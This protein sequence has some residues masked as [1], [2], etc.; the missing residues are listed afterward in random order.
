MAA[1]PKLLAKPPAGGAATSPSPSPW[2]RDEK[3]RQEKKKEADLTVLRDVEIAELEEKGYLAP[4][5]QERL[6]RLRLDQE[7]ERRV[8]EASK[9]DD[10]AGD[11]D[12]DDITDRAAVGLTIHLHIQYAQFSVLVCNSLIKILSSNIQSI[13]LMRCN[14]NYVELKS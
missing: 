14:E 2:E 7:F 6:R 12:N 4:E 13:S 9:D 8:Q 10:D 3:E 1:K 11:S 5:E